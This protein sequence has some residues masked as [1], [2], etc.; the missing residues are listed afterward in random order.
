MPTETFNRVEDLIQRIG[1]PDDNTD[2]A[3]LQNI[4]EEAH[5]DLTANVGR[6]FIEDLRVRKTSDDE[7]TQD[8]DLKLTPI[9]EVDEILLSEHEIVDDSNYTVDKQEGTVTFD[10]SF[11]DDEL[12]TGKTLRFK[13]KPEI[14]KQI[15]LWRAVEIVKNQEIVQLEDSEQVALNRNALREAKRLEN[16][17]NRASGPGTATDGI[18]RRGTP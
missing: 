18:R 3:D 1:Y 12:Y 11:V 16:M 15:E 4:L 14:F 5:Q 2:E 17:V 9:F 6:N 10:Q 7:I 8:F 13:Y